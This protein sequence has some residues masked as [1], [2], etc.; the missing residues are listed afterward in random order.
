MLSFV[1]ELFLAEHSAFEKNEIDL[2]PG[3]VIQH[4]ED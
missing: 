2:K 1:S 3:N 4:I